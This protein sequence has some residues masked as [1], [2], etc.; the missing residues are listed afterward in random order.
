M[1]NGIGEAILAVSAAREVERERSRCLAMTPQA[2]TVAVCDEVARREDLFEG[3]RNPRA[4]AW[5]SVA[6]DLVAARWR[7]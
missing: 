3:A 1:A 7:P 6:D 4:S 2:G 5:A